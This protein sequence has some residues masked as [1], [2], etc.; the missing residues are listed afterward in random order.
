MQ[1]FHLWL[2]QNHFQEMTDF[3]H[4]IEKFEGDSIVY[5]EFINNNTTELVKVVS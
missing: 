3:F 4:I 5:A 2:L 1:Q